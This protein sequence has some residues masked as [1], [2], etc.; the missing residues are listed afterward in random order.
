MLCRQ[1]KKYI[2]RSKYKAQF[3]RRGFFDIIEKEYK[4]KVKKQIK[5]SNKLDLDYYDKMVINIEKLKTNTEVSKAEANLFTVLNNFLESQSS[6]YSYFSGSNGQLVQRQI[7]GTLFSDELSATKET[8]ENFI[9][10]LALRLNAKDP[11]VIG[12]NFV[13]RQGH[14]INAISL[15]QDIDNPDY[16][17][18]GVYDSNHHGEKRY[19]DLECKRNKCVLR[20]NEYYD[21]VDGEV[22]RLRDPYYIQLETLHYKER[23]VQN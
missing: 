23:E 7:V 4:P 13:D 1:G 2:I 5:K 19:L 17:Y 15:A 20:N 11:I 14:A 8:P 10:L 22:I 18:I 6:A 21:N 12:G 16:Y 9:D 3:L